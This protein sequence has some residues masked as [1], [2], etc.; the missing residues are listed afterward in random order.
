MSFWFCTNIRF[1]TYNFEIRY[2]QRG[3][4]TIFLFSTPETD[5]T[6]IK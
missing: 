6:F 3:Y 2:E 5:E 4:Q 1:Y